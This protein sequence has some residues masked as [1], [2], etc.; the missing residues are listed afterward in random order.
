MICQNCGKEHDGS[1][2]SGKFCCKSCAIAYGNKQR[3]NR[4]II[5]KHISEGVKKYNKE[6]PKKL[7]LYHYTCEKCGKEFDSPK[8]RDGRH[9]HCEDCK[10]KVVH[11]KDINETT[12]I[13]ELS[14]RTI[15]KILNR[16]NKGCS[17]CG[18]NESTC[19]IHHIIEKSN[20]GT[21]EH[22]NLIIVCPNCHRIIHTTDKYSIQFLQNLSM[23]K[24]FIDWKNYYYPSN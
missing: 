22:N 17:I 18:W 24:Q 11:Y 15:T 16:A 13:K 9:I 23:E 7:I 1:Y 14:K 12:S 10:R 19:D 6:N 20:G 8:I 3:K 5:N 4:D 21:D 2:G